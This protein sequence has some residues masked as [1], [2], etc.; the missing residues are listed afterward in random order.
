MHAKYFKSSSAGIF[1]LAPSVD[2]HVWCVCV[3]VCVCVCT[4][5]GFASLFCTLQ[6]PSLLLWFKGS[7][8]EN[9]MVLLTVNEL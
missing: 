8:F 2:L 3:S 9:I 7:L 6:N 4:H 5:A 1:D